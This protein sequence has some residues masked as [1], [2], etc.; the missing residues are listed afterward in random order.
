M[1]VTE[2]ALRQITGNASKVLGRTLQGSALTLF[3]SSLLGRGVIKQ[4]VHELGY[5]INY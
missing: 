5:E 1:T 4:I 3:A 2:S